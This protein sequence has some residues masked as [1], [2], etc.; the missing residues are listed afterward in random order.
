MNM[1]ASSLPALEPEA[2]EKFREAGR[3][4]REARELGVSLIQPGT[5]LRE[6]MEAVEGFI[7][8][9][10]AGMAFPAQTSLNACAAHY[11]PSPKD[12]SEYS[13][14]DIVKID[15]GVEVDGYVADNA[16]TVYLGDDPA[17]HK[18]IEASA[19]G[20]DAAINTVADGIEVREV[21]AAI[22]AAIEAHGYRPVYNLTGHGVGHYKVHCPPQIPASPDKHDTFVL[23]EGM[24]I[25]IE[26]FATNG[27]GQVYEKG[28]AEIF[29]LMREPRKFKNIDPAVYD[30]IEGMKGLPFARRTFQGLPSDAIETTLARLLRTGCLAVYPP[31]VDP[32]PKTR[33]AQTEHTMIVT[34]DGA[35]VI[36]RA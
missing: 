7:V 8:S 30:V 21:S 12:Q 32:D 27:K 35:E 5:K 24:V 17:D 14:N 31:L 9:Q 36:T 20:L 23:R 16:Q 15:I 6:V 22:E 3:I 25:A 1:S 33:I 18:L 2:R 4:A 10:G 13:P 19:A 29:M 28:R 26:P 34:A 11:C